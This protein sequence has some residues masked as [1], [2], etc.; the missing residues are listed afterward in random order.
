MKRKQSLACSQDE[1]SLVSGKPALTVT[2]FREGPLFLIGLKFK[3]PGFISSM[4]TL[5]KA[6]IAMICEMN[7]C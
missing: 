6:I 5:V 2:V 7:R 3:N 4:F 1:G